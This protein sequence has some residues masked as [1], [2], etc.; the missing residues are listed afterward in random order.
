MGTGP[1]V[2]VSLILCDAMQFPPT[3]TNKQ[4]NTLTEVQEKN[5]IIFQAVSQPRVPP[6]TFMTSPT[7][8]GST[9]LRKMTN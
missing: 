5:I 1:H 8:A 4:K 9:N 7:L 2:H 3:K 6:P